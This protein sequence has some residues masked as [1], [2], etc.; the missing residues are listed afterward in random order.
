MSPRKPSK[1]W[2][3]GVKQRVCSEHFIDSEP[4]LENP[5]PILHM[6]YHSSPRAR[7]MNLTT[8]NSRRQLKYVTARKTVKQQSSTATITT[9]KMQEGSFNKNLSSSLSA[10]DTFASHTN[11]GEKLNESILNSPVDTFT[12][13]SSHYC[14]PS[15]TDNYSKEGLHESDFNPPVPPSTQGP[16]MIC[17]TPFHPL[18]TEAEAIELQE[19]SEKISF[20]ESEV[21]HL[22]IV[23][24]WA[25]KRIKKQNIVIKALTNYRK[26]CRCKK[27]VYQQLLKKDGD[28]AFYTGIESFHSFTKLHSLISPYVRRRWR[29]LKRSTSNTTR[30]LK[31]EPN[32]FGPKRKLCST[33]EFLMMLMKL[34]LGLFNKD[35]ADRFEVSV[36]S[37]SAI[38][39]TWIKASS[40][41]LSLLIFLPQ[42]GSVV[43]TRPPRFQSM[44]DLFAILDGTEFFIQ[45]PKNPD[46]QKLTWSDYKHHNTL[47]VLVCIAPNSMIT[48]ISKAY[49]GSISDKELT[50]RSEFLDYVPPYTQIMYDKGF[51]LTNECASRF[52]SVSVPPARK[53]TAQMTPGEIVKTKK[54]ANM[55]ILVEQVIRRLKLFQILS[56]ELSI[57]LIKSFDDILIICAALSNMRKPIFSD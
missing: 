51:Q 39:S 48:F 49:G 22:N 35:L 29:G 52:I 14:T 21:R 38:V 24:K 46:L 5:V 19:V 56:T 55:R 54:I 41:V 4:T 50:I 44:P 9:S 43:N 47:K 1:L 26:M 32:L 15:I 6:G 12:S 45:T 31:K 42:Q 11:S 33:D 34:R 27:P 16:A 36:G 23:N 3:V 10:M 2:T 30:N 20:L 53:G 28:C 18:V 40:A 57:S 17:S 25:L 37:V 8:T 7:K 13:P